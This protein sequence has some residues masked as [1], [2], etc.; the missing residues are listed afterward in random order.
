MARALNPDGTAPPP[1]PDAESSLAAAAQTG[2]TR[3]AA[4]SAIL[5]DYLVER[6]SQQLGVTGAGDSVELGRSA[7]GMGFDM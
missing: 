1:H 5:Y 2:L 6:W 3:R 4:N 7:G